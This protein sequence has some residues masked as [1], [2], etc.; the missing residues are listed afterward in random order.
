M[1]ISSRENK[2]LWRVLNDG[3]PPF[4]NEELKRVMKHTCTP[5]PNFDIAVKL[6]DNGYFKG[7]EKSQR[8]ARNKQLNKLERG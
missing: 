3:S 4:T 2:V 1:D 6:R 8:R 7:P 5:L